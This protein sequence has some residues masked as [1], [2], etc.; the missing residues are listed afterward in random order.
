MAFSSINGRTMGM[1]KFVNG[2]V[3]FIEGVGTVLYQCKNGEHHTPT[4]VYYIPWLWTSVIIIRHLDEYGYEIGIKGGV[5]SL[6]DEEQRLLA[7]I[8]HSP[9]RLYKL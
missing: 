6:R 1:M 5:L 3:V 7:R 2:F 4:N 8:H 9:G